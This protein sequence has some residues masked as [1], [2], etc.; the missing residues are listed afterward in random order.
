MAH[1][2]DIFER[3]VMLPRKAQRAERM[4]TIS[5]HNV[6]Y[7]RSVGV[8]ES[9]L[10]VVRCGVSFALRGPV[11]MLRREHYRIGTLGRLVEKR[12]VDDRLRALALL[13]GETWRCEL[14][15]AGE[16]PLCSALEALATELGIRAQVHFEGALRH[17]TAGIWMQSLDVFVLACKADANGDMDGI[18]VVLIEAMSQRVP[19]VSTKISEI[20]ELVI[21]EQTGLL[22]VPADPRSLATQL[23]RLLDASDG[24]ELRQY[25]PETAVPHVQAEFGQAV[26]LDRPMQYFS[27]LSPLRSEGR[28]PP[29][30]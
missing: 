9:R 26:N 20:P 3:G 17:D 1:A 21:H 27:A 22:A 4:R 10:A 18:P 6:A 2:N 28:D 23:R 16:G 11:A 7:L 29:R 19:V 15:I 24:P 12:G 8:P 13:R 14:S 30:P 5:H 25:L